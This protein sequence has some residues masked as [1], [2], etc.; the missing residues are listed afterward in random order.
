MPESVVKTSLWGRDVGFLSWDATRT[1]GIF[2]YAP[3][4]LDSG[5]DISPICMPLAVARARGNTPWHGE[6]DRLYQGLPALFVDSLPDKWGGTLFREWLQTNGIPLKD[7]TPIEHLSFI[8]TRGMGA[9]TFEPVMPLG[10]DIPFPVD[11]QK[12]YDFS[13]EVLSRQHGIRLAPS[14]SVLWKDLVKVSSSPGGR[15]PKAIVAIN[16]AGE[17]ISGQA[18]VPAGF[19]HCILKYDSGDGYPYAKMEYIFYRIACLAGIHM[20]PSSLRQYGPVSHF[21]TE[22]FDRIGNRRL[23]LQSL[24]AIAPEATSYEDAMTLLRKLRCPAED[25]RQLFLIACFNVLCQNVDDHTKNLSFLMDEKGI[26]RLAPA[27]DM[28]FAWELEGYSWDHAHEMSIDGKRSDIGK[29]S[30]LRLAASGDLDHAER[31]YND[32]LE[33]SYTFRHFAQ[34]EELPAVFIDRVEKV[35]QSARDA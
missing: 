1:R 26:W 8:G 6:S 13:K 3:S 32:V 24:A 7:I 27:Y 31:L 34:E 17:V 9:L 2:E 29:D 10:D 11:V 4:F 28:T 35:L 21:V 15:H 14:E 25:F 16:E 18:D 19:R 12:L 5:L 33:A 23:H 20:M 22:R 30:L